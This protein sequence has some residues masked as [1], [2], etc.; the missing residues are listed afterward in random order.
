MSTSIQPRFFTIETNESSRWCHAPLTRCDVS[1]Q[2]VVCDP[3]ANT[4]Q[5]GVH[6][7][8]TSMA[9][10]TPREFFGLEA[11]D[12][13]VLVVAAALALLFANSPLGPVQPF[14]RAEVVGRVAS[15][16][17]QAAAAVDQRRADGGLLPAGRPGD[18]ARGLRG[19]AVAA[20][21]GGAAD[22]RARR[23]G[24][25][26]ALYVAFN[27]SDPVALRG[28]AIPAATD[29]AFALGVLALLGSPRAARSRCS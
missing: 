6:H 19:R 17:Q 9:I 22:R 25:A 24:R 11:A 4:L 29:I 18:Q 14:P 15:R 8:S 7:E 10:N 12:G 16:D 1:M 3:A 23:H 20:L 13:I 21:A 27:W 26:G 5:C 2:P 28:W